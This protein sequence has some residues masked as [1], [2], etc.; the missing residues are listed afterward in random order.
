MR[1]IS[2]ISDVARKL[3][4]TEEDLYFY[5]DSIA[6]LKV[7][8]DGH[9]KAKLIL[10]TAITPTKAGEGKT[11]TSIGLTDGLRAIGKNA[12]A[13]LREPS[14]GPVFGVKGGGCG[15]GEANLYPEEDINLNFTGDIHAI[16]AVNNLIC[17]MIDNEAYQNSNLDVD[18]QRIIFPRT[19]DMNDRSLRNIDVATSGKDGEK[20]PSSFVITAAC[21]VMSCFCLASDEEDFLNR[22]E[23]ILVAYSRDGKEIKVKDLR[24]RTSIKR[25]IHQAL[26]PNLV[27]TYY[28]S[29]VIV[30]GGPFAN[31]AH[32]TNSIIATNLGMKL[33]DYVVTEAGFGSDLGMEKYL[34]IVSS[35]SHTHPDLVVLVCSTRALKMHGGVAFEKLGYLNNDALIKGLANLDKHIE[36]IKLYHLPVLVAI[37]KFASDNSEELEIIKKHLDS[38]SI[39]SEIISSYT[40]GPEGA[41]ALARK[42][43]EILNTTSSDDF[44]QIVNESMDIFTK[45]ETIAKKIYG[46]SGVEY[47]PEVYKQIEQLN[48]GEEK[49][50]HVCISKTPNSLSDDAHLLN[51]PTHT[52]HVKSLRV[53]K[54]ASFI[55]PLT[56]AV[57]T[58]PGL[59]KIP[60]GK[61]ILR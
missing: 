5:G 49:N 22:V 12:I 52:L 1:K 37:N 25:L 50:Y 10:T 6:K 44:K 36:N 40:D 46:A 55:V 45:I 48:V 51:V 18:P 35:I 41:T 58:M 53:F 13:C 24:I 61:D 3:A 8:V 28:S 15:G 20:H 56:G 54:G 42:A 59:P 34:D 30:H 19:M 9:K 32:G 26:Y 38:M 31:I 7:R 16:S 23:N 2:K 39:P 14:I 60:R 43:V 33:A 27:Q 4:L 57:M 47:T 21:E 29:P 17:A 11:T